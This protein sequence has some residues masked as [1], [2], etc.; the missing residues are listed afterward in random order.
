SRFSP[1]VRPQERKIRRYGKLRL[2]VARSP[3]LAGGAQH[4]GLYRRRSVH[5]T[6]RRSRTRLVAESA[7]PART[8]HFPPDLLCPVTRR[9][10]FCRP[11]FQPDFSKTN[12][13]HQC[14]TSLLV[15]ELESRVSVAR[16][17]PD[18]V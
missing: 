2:S 5:S 17:I 4:R 18:A 16:P 9:A 12:R 15:R 8:R 1:D 3:F 14:R 11:S 7:T 10:R 13:S 6:P